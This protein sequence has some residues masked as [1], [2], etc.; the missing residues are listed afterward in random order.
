MY[1]LWL[2]LITKYGTSTVPRKSK[3]YDATGQL[4]L[5]SIRYSGNCKTIIIMQFNYSFKAAT[6]IATILL[7]LQHYKIS[8]HVQKWKIFCEQT[9]IWT[10]CSV[11]S[12]HVKCPKLKAKGNLAKPIVTVPNLEKRVLLFISSSYP[13]NRL[14][15]CR[16]LW[17]SVCVCVCMCEAVYLY[18]VDILSSNLSR[19]TKDSILPIACGTSV[20]HCIHVQ[21]QENNS[22]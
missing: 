1:R 21:R 12:K 4:E 10:E 16:Q 2:E 8:P 14:F 15:W 11:F 13:G 19:Q 20:V 6:V 7:L 17:V 3:H 18:V 5:I 9:G 22:S